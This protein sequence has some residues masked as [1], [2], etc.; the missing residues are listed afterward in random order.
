MLLQGINVYLEGSSPLEHIDVL[1]IICLVVLLSFV[2]IFAVLV[3]FG[4]S[5]L[6]CVKGFLIFF[7]LQSGPSNDYYS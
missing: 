5:I 2:I 4:I 3:V 1:P 7:L 6:V